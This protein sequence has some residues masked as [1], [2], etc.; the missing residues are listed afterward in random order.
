MNR[1]ITYGVCKDDGM[2][3]SRVG[4]EVAWPVLQYEDMLP[5]NNF[6]PTYKLERM[7]VLSVTDEW[8]RIKW[9][10]KIPIH[11]KNRHRVF[12]GFKPLAESAS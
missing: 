9:T 6:T 8:Y 3:V 10:K 4:S 1:I 7:P 2:V 5:E 11:L 12:W